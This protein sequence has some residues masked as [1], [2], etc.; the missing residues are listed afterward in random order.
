M[1][2]RR[3]HQYQRLRDGQARL[4]RARSRASRPNGYFY[5]VSDI[6]NMWWGDGKYTFNQAA[7]AP[8]IALQGGTESNAG[9]SYIGKI[10]SQVFGAQIGANIT[11]NFQLTGRLR[12]DSVEDRFRLSAEERNLQQLELSDLREGRDARV[13]PAAQRRAVLHQS[14][15]HDAASTTAAGPARTPTTTTAIRSSRP[16]STKAW[17][18]GARPARRGR[19]RLH[20]TSTNKKWVF[21]ATD[22]WYNYGNAL[23]PEN[24][25]DW[26]LD[27]RYRFSQYARR[28]PYHGLL[29]AVSVHRSARFR[30][31]SAA[32]RRRRAARRTRRLG[33]TVVRRLAALQV[34][35]S[36]AR[37]RLLAERPTTPWL[38]ARP[39]C[40]RAFFFCEEGLIT[41][42]LIGASLVREVDFELLLI[43]GGSFSQ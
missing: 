37:V 24:T 4:R 29:A 20:F 3:R 14:Q 15:R 6:V 34:Q 23:A 18:T 21:I 1:P 42:S 41:K 22:A 32:R 39:A 10:N 5:G 19:S 25:N 7:C 13:L 28:D 12:S 43:R 26:M 30:T 35:P 2:G 36:P 16:A 40:G 17:P 38:S 33:S 9:Q 27:G 31:R 11:K 8:F